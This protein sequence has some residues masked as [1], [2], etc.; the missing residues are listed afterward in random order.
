MHKLKAYK[1]F[2]KKEY[3]GENDFD[4]ILNWCQSIKYYTAPLLTWVWSK[5]IKNE[6]L[7][8]FKHNEA[9]SFS[10]HYKYIKFLEIFVWVVFIWCLKC[11]LWSIM[12]LF[13]L[14]IF[15]EYILKIR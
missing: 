13:Y 5:S 14:Y 6:S 15:W 9:I 8:L 1:P 4:L 2:L 7:F 10:Y 3:D 12:S 11:K